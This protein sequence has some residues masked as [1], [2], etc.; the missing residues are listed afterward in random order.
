MMKDKTNNPRYRGSE[1]LYHQVTPNNP[2]YRGS[3]QWYHQV[4]P[5]NP[6]YRGSEQWYHQVTPCSSPCCTHITYT[7]HLVGTWLWGCGSI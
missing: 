2:R 7:V 5:N 6:R 3:E 1:Q 4:T